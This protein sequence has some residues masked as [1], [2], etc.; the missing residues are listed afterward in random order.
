MKASVTL[1]FDVSNPH[2]VHD[3]VAFSTLRSFR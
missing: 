1:G 2:V 3:F